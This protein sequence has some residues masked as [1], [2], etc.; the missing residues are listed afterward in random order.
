MLRDD[1]RSLMRWYPRIFFACHTRH[2]RDPGSARVLSAH[3]ASILDHL[4]DQDGVTLGWLASHMGVT[5][6]TMSVHV[7]RLVEKGYVRKGRDKEDGRRV[8][9]RITGAGLRV[10]EAKSVL[11]EA[12]VREMLKGLEPAVRERALDGL[13]VLAE[14]AGEMGATSIG[15]EAS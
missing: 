11:D 4:D 8:L 7:D 2:V 5:P 10:R 1:V 9:L 3:Q 13:R 6:G 14:A 15:K 12:R